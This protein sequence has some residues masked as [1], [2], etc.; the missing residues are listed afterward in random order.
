[1]RLS[2]KYFRI[3]TA[4]VV[5]PVL[6]T[7]LAVFTSLFVDTYLT[8]E[9]EREE[10]F[11]PMIGM[12]SLTVVCLVVS[13]IAYKSYKERFWNGDKEVWKNSKWRFIKRFLTEL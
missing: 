6:T 8:K 4:F 11:W 7:G 13:V 3:R 10:I 1:M 5:L 12:I 2:P 9:S